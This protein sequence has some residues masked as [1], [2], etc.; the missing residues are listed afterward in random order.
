M[1]LQLGAKTKLLVVGTKEL[2]R[3]KV[4]RCMEINVAGYRVKESN[5]ERLL[6]VIVNNNM[7]WQNHI[8]GDSQNTGLL[9]KLEQ[10][11]AMIKK[12]SSVMPAPRFKQ[13]YKP[14]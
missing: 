8:H 13:N 7:T 12:L 10:R 6:G 11:S 3:A 5:S 14:R 9:A 2:R 1:N 4:D